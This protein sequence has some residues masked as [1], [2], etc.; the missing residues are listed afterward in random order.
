MSNLP[1]QGT[2]R[3]GR[4]R[5]LGPAMGFVGTGEAFRSSFGLLVGMALLAIVLQPTAQAF[6]E[7]LVM[8]APFGASAVLL[9]ALPNSPLAQPFSAVFGNM[10]SAFVGVALLHLTRDALSLAVLAPPLAVLAMQLTRSLHPPG[11]AVA[12]TVALAPDRA[13]ALGWLYP[14]LPVALGTLILVVIASFYGSLTGRRYPFRQPAGGTETAKEDIPPLDRIGVSRLE[15]AQLLQ[16]FRQSANIGVEDLARLIAATDILAA[17]HQTDRLPLSEIM[18]RDLVTVAPQTSL[19]QVAEIF[20]QRGFTSLPVVSQEGQYLGVIFQI[21]LIR[22]GLE[23]AQRSASR[24]SRAM[25]RLMN[26]DLARVPTAADVMD[27]DLPSLPPD[28]ALEA[29]LPLLAR[30]PN[31]AVPILEDGRILG[32]VTRTDLIAALARRRG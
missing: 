6:S 30:G 14:I 29:A 16:D 27:Q 28:A 18:S 23:E 20:R 21:H 5:H 2:A 24:F 4:L 8:I 19:H 22:K 1:T 31:D 7:T 26:R 13:L 10:I 25:G 3:L 11:G 9:F 12:L 17:S 32:I 15:L